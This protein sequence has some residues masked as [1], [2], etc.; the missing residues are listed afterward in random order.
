MHVSVLPGQIVGR[1]NAELEPGMAHVGKGPEGVDTIAPGRKSMVD[2]VVRSATGLAREDG[3]ERLVMVDD[4]GGPRP[5]DKQQLS[6][7]RII[8]RQLAER[9]GA[10]WA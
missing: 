8:L 4:S 9:I 2:P 7:R 5:E 3:P 6:E 1:S 10:I